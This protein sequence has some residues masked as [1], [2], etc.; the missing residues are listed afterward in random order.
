[1]QIITLTTDFGLQDYYVAATKGAIL[2]QIPNANIIDISH[3]IRPF[4]V[5]EAVFQLKCCYFNFPPGTIHIIGVDSEP[6][7]DDN[8]PSL[9]MVMQFKDQY[10]ISNDNGFF[11]TFLEDELPQALYKLEKFAF[12]EDYYKFPTKNT[13]IPLAAQISKNGDLK[14]LCV[15]TNNFK[16]AFIQKPTIEHNRMLGSIVNIDGYGNIITNITKNDFYRFGTNTPF[17]IYYVNK[18]IFIDIISKTYNDVTTGEKVA[19]FN[20]SD[21][22]E[23]AINKGANGS[24]GGANKLFGGRIGDVIT[25]EFHPPGSAKDIHSLF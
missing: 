6:I 12:A 24:T 22:L 23:I 7:F 2:H 13:F 25:I 19:I 11:G 16:K 3:S 18:T 17:I 4:N 20:S 21:L 9:P 14:E 15:E 8:N 5:A 1:M 10:F